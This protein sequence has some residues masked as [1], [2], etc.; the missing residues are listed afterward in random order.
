MDKVGLKQKPDEKKGGCYLNRLCQI[1]DYTLNSRSKLNQY[2]SFCHFKKAR[3]CENLARIKAEMPTLIHAQ[4]EQSQR[5]FGC[6]T[7]AAERLQIRS[8]IKRDDPKTVNCKHQTT[9]FAQN[10]T[11][12]SNICVEREREITG[13]GSSPGSICLARPWSDDNQSPVLPLQWTCTDLASLIH[14]T[15]KSMRK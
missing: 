8:F 6:E 4:I 12:R 13:D 9:S 11:Q 10:Q 2:S 1:S 3:P 7:A 15:Q 14:P 5:G